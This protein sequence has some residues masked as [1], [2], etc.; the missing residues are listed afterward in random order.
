MLVMI[1]LEPM[2]CHGSLEEG[3]ILV[4]LHLEHLWCA[5]YPGQGDWW[6]EAFLQV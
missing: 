4:S 3:G 1:G 6:V 5:H 2:A